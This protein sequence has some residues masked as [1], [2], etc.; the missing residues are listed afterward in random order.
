MDHQSTVGLGAGLYGADSEVAVWTLYRG[1]GAVQ[2]SKVSAVV[3][4][5][6]S[7]YMGS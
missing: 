3:F 4:V 1:A 6:I 5:A 7:V 2:L